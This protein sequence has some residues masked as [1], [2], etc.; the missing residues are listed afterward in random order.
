MNELGGPKRVEQAMS[1]L[2]R[3]QGTQ[4][5]FRRAHARGVGFRGRFTASPDAAA[6]TSAE[7]FQGNEVDA[8]VRLSNGSANP[9]AVDRSSPKRG[10]VLG[11]GVRF[12]AVLGRARGLGLAQ[13]RRLPRPQAR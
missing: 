6:L 7:H 11:L 1:V 5:G 2:D 12:R 10:G 9:Y 3:F 4:P 8:I 13:R